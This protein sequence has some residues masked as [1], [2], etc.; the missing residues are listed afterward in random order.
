MNG[1]ITIPMDH[2]LEKLFSSLRTPEPPADLTEKILARIA[3]RERRILGIKIALSACVFGISTG[4]SVAGYFDLMANLSQSGFFQI[5][6][7]AFSDFSAI[8]A[9][10]P[11]FALSIAESFPVFTAALLLSG[12]LFATWSMAALIDEASLFR[13]GRAGKFFRTTP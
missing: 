1:V 12:V 10:F 8:T 13:A 9:N 3:R 2:D 5:F 4:I 6:S 11:D 7:L